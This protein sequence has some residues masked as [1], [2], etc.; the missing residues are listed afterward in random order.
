MHVVHTDSHLFLLIQQ[1]LKLL[2]S[3][4]LRE[5]V[6]FSVFSAPIEAIVS[7]FPKT[8]NSDQSNETDNSSDPAS[9]RSNASAST[10][11][12]ELASL[13]S[14]ICTIVFL[15]AH[16]GVP[17]PRDVCDEGDRGNHIKPEIE[18][19]EVAYLA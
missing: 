3:D 14:V 1:V 8:T 17:D 9:S 5:F 10:G 4:Q 16:D 18:G 19:V 2:L 11:T 7:L 13:I 6:V 15:F 12:C